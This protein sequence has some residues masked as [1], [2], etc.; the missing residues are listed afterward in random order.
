MRKLFRDA[1]VVRELKDGLDKIKNHEKEKKKK[2]CI[3][4]LAV[5]SSVLVLIALAIFVFNWLRRRREEAFELFDDDDYY[6]YDYYATDE[7]FEE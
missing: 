2:E 5:V 1:F 6:G 4:V 3:T 7:D